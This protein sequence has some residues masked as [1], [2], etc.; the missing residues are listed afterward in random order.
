MC[1]LYC[2]L[3]QDNNLPLNP[4]FKLLILVLENRYGLYLNNDSIL[5]HDWLS[6]HSSAEILCVGW[7]QL[8]LIKTVDK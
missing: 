1:Y 4:K 7:R 8:I 2:F 3:I 6:Y 5:K